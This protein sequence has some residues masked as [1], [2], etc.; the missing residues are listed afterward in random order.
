[1]SPEPTSARATIEAW[2][3]QRADRLAPMRF[4]FLDALE[5]RVAS[6]HGEVRRMLDERL[7]TLLVAYAEELAATSASAESATTACVP[8]STP[9]GQLLDHISSKTPKREGHA[10]A[11]SSVF[12]ELA[13]LEGFRNTWSAVRSESQLRQ[14]LTFAPTSAGPLNS[15]ALVHRAMALMRELSPGYLRHFLS[16]VDDLSWLEQIDAGAA[17][18]P[19]ARSARM[20]KRARK[21][22]GGMTPGNVQ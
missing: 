7:A 18:K 12:P 3:E 13:A 19:T 5:R 6:H 4:R 1:M 11:Q 17:G 9:L 16:Y 15:A 20:K 21:K 8:P 14:S 10:P 22:L 2:R